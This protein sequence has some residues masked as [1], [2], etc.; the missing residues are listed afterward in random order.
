MLWGVSQ[1]F[2]P[3]TALGSD[4]EPGGEAGAR[5]SKLALLENSPTCRGGNCLG[6][7]TCYQPDSAHLIRFLLGGQKRS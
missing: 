3:G 6:T 1:P 7:D 4:W 5:M 2:R